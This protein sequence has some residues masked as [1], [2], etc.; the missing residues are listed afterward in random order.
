MKRYI[1][2]KGQGYIETVDEMIIKNKT[3]KFELKRLCDE[4]NLSDRTG[5]YYISRRSC[6]NWNS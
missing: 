5:Y 1:N 2:R 6:K 3:D 4:Y